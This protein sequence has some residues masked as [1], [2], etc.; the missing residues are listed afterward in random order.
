M[1]RETAKSPGTFQ[2]FIYEFSDLPSEKP[3]DNLIK[4]KI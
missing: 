1:F 3:F 2:I 4:R